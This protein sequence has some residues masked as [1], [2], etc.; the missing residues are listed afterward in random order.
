[1][2]GDSRDDDAELAA[3]WRRLRRAAQ[4]STVCVAVVVLGVIG[5]YH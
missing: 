5:L 4:F 3:E 1:V 2:S